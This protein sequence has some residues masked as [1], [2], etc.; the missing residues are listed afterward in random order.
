ME[1]FLQ[2]ILPQ[3]KRRLKLVVNCSGLALKLLKQRNKAFD[4]FKDLV[5]EDMIELGNHTYS[6][7]SI[8]GEYT[9]TKPLSYEEQEREI[10]VQNELIMELF[11]K[12][13]VVFRAPYFNYNKHT[14]E[15]LAKNQIKFDL[16]EYI[17]KD[18]FRATE[19][20]KRKTRLGNIFSIST[21]MKLSPKVWVEPIQI[22]KSELTQHGL[23]NIVFHPYELTEAYSH[24][25]E[26]R[27][28]FFNL[29]SQ[30]VQF[31]HCKDLLE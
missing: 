30:D 26:T 12:R 9:G 6:H 29:L 14:L 13:P 27:N 4:I 8:T 3:V 15:I 25:K 19:A 24:Y 5:A 10:S 22:Y 31:V 21:N 7:R 1:H 11:G 20:I 18:E 2:E 23:H 28:N 16:S 17:T